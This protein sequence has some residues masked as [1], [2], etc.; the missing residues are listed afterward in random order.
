[1]SELVSELS[2]MDAALSKLR[3]A[4]TPHSF[5]TISAQLWQ[6]AENAKSANGVAAES[7]AVKTDFASSVESAEVENDKDVILYGSKVNEN[8]PFYKMLSGKSTQGKTSKSSVRSA[9]K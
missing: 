1:M 6:S 2:Q 4:A 7:S 8:S 3:Y 5:Q 9:K